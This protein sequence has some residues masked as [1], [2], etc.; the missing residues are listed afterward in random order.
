MNSISGKPLPTSDALTL[1]MS[2]YLKKFSDLRRDITRVGETVA[3]GVNKG[4]RT[5]RAERDGAC[6]LC[7]NLQ[8][9]GHEDS[10]DKTATG[11]QQDR[12]DDYLHHKRIHCL[13]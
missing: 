10:S 4:I 9:F 2:A 5:Y 13:V 11:L 1:T 8:P 7:N 6:L 3:W 12:M